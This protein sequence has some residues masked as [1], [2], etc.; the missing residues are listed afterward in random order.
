METI[1]VSEAEVKTIIM[2]L[3]PKNSTAYDGI[4]NKILKCCVH[5]ISKPLTYICNCSLSTGIFP[6]RCKF[7]I[8]RPI[9]KKGGQKE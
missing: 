6:E 9:H 5:S 1:P 8:V 2:S 7:A 3:K 4:P